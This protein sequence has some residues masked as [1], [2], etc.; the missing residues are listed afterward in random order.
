MHDS[1]PQSDLVLFLRTAKL[2]ATGERDMA[3]DRWIHCH[4]SIG[5]GLVLS[6]HRKPFDS[7]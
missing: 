3:T 6:G 5:I 7:E 4:Q 2:L 1:P